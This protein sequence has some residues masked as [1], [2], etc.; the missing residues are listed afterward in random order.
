MDRT[1]ME[2]QKTGTGKPMLPVDFREVYVVY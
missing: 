2:E 1:E